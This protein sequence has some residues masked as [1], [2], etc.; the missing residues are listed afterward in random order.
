M[1]P[2]Q[3]IDPAAV[4]PSGPPAVTPGAV[5]IALRDGSTLRLRPVRPADEPA[6]LRLLAG[7]D[8]DDRMLRFFSAAADVT[9]AARD[10]ARVEDDRWGIVAVAGDD[11]TVLAH[12]CAVREAPGSEA[13]EVAFVVARE[14]RGEGVATAL[15]AL[16]ADRARAAGIARLTAVVLPE[17]HAMIDVFRDSGLQPQVRAAA[18]ELHVTMPSEL[19][20]QAR[21]RFDLRDAEAAAAAVSH[22]LRPASVAVVGASERAGSVGGAV[23]RNLVEGSFTG[24]LHAVNPRGGTVAGLPAA[25]SLAE[26][27]TPVELAVIA[28]PAVAVL[29]A[30]RDCAAQGVRALVVLS[31]GFGEAGEEGRARQRELVELCRRA[32]MRLVGPN[33]LGV[34]NTDPAVRLDATFAPTQPPAGHVAFLSQSGALGIAV[35]DTAQELGVGL[36]SPRSSTSTE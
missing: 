27:G 11:E 4:T 23:L 19:G 22:V 21:E 1:T 6:L 35:I 18:G 25:R 7:L 5:D 14:L 36:C 13:A 8:L 9:A 24:R 17:N 28:I 12:G 30:A 10:A 33:C 29:E 3:S 20:A 32:G 16:L 15:L 2:S 31:D 26:V 34:L